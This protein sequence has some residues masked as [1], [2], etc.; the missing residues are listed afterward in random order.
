MPR[1]HRHRPKQG[2]D[3]DAS[4]LSHLLAGWKRT[5]DHRDGS[6]YV[7]P[8]S[9]ASSQKEYLCPGCG[10]TITPGTAHLVAWR[11]DGLMGDAADIAARRHW[12]THCWRIR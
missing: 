8:V 5:E 12:H 11:A 10:Q 7:Q 9:G 1:H 3:D 2:S 6:W 4:D